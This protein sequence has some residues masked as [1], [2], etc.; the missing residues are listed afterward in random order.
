M[1]HLWAHVGFFQRREFSTDCDIMTDE[2]FTRMCSICL[3][4][5]ETA[6]EK[7]RHY[8]EV[9]RGVFATYRLCHLCE[10]VDHDGKHVT[11]I[12]HRQ[13]E[14]PFECRRC[15]FRSSSRMALIDHF[16]KIHIGTTLLMCPFCPYTTQ[17]SV[18]EKLKPVVF[19]KNYVAH[20]TEHGNVVAKKCSCCSYKFI[21]DSHF[22]KHTKCHQTEQHKW[23]IQFKSFKTLKDEALK[24][25]PRHEQLTLLKCIECDTQFPKAEDHFDKL[26]KCDRCAF[27]T[28]C[29]RAYWKHIHLSDCDPENKQRF[30]LAVTKDENFVPPKCSFKIRKN[31]EITKSKDYIQNFRMFRDFSYDR[32]PTVI[33]QTQEK[34]EIDLIKE[35][36]EKL[37][38]MTTARRTNDIPSYILDGIAESLFAEDKEDEDTMKFIKGIRVPFISLCEEFL[39]EKKRKEEEDIEMLDDSCEIDKS[40]TEPAPL[41]DE[42]AIVEMSESTQVVEDIQIDEIVEEKVVEPIEE[43]KIVEESEEKVVEDTPSIQIDKIV[44]EKVVELMEEEKVVEQTEEIHVEREEE[45]IS[46]IQEDE[47]MDQQ[48]SPAAPSSSTPSAISA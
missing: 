4:V 18:S 37:K 43:E 34:T 26:Q 13:N 39:A 40:T 1:Y 16:S 31:L 45:Q 27:E 46:T 30:E 29:I 20:V 32:K 10:T 41:E 44:E 12:K 19:A 21:D 15:K 7:T 33:P 6:F 38:N 48:P 23:P 17:I 36:R 3:T 28:T 22:E 11:E 2:K 24:T 35:R 8:L 47:E 42:D 25:K 5:F 14:L 9:H